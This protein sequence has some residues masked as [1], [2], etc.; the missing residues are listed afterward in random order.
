VFANEIWRQ[1]IL[2]LFAG[3]ALIAGFGV[4]INLLLPRERT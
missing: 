2:T 4:A 1:W 3:L